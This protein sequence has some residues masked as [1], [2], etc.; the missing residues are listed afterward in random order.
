MSFE[1]DNMMGVKRTNRSAALRILH[2]RGSMSRKRLSESIKLTP[3]AITKIVGEMIA[4][5]LLTEGSMLPGSGVGR[6]EVMVELNNRARAALGIFINLRQAFVSAVWLDGSVIFSE[7]FTLPPKAPAEETVQ[8]LCRR[9]TELTDEKSLDR[10]TLLGV[11]VAMRGVISP[12]G[13]VVRNSFGALSERDY[14][15]C[16]RIEA[17]TGLPCLMSNNV[18]ALFAAQMYLSREGDVGSQF[19]LRCEAGIGASFSI[20][21]RIW[22]GSSGQ[23]AEI[24]HI[25]VV[26]R[27]GKPCSCGKSGCLETIASPGAMEQD[28][29]ALFSEERTPVL[30][31]I[32]RGREPEDLTLEDVFEAARSGDG[33]IASLV[34][35]SAVALAA[36]LKGVIYTLDPGK[37]VLYGRMFENP[38]YLS[39]L[40]AEMREGVDSGHN[41]PIEKSRLNHKLEDRAAGLLV[42]EDF[43]DKGGLA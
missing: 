13:R 32:M 40:I 21:E 15:I 9:L 4:E 28:A 3:A 25:P 18:R 19:F 12:D 23:C 38:Y 42:V 17:L 29:L 26:R 8:M 36:A 2:E 1:G 37:I 7:S 11:G 31:R 30:W 5:G 6:R 22:L 24:G 41:V 43:F 34:D 14:P 35:R 10:E 27:G 39:K 20:G 33:E 16:E